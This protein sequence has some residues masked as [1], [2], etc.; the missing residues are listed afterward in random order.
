MSN[1]QSTVLKEAFTSPGRDIQQRTLQVWL[2]VGEHCIRVAPSR[3]G[4]QYSCAHCDWEACYST[5][6]VSNRFQRVLEE[7][8]TGD[9]VEHPCE[10][11]CDLSCGMNTTMT[12]DGLD[13]PI[14][15][16]NVSTTGTT[17]G[18]IPDG[19]VTYMNNKLQYSTSGKFY[20][21]TDDT[22]P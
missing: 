17:D 13:D 10:V 3:G 4:M 22:L 9:A 20:T 12:F 11:R 8:V 7:Y 14:P 18:S 21:I 19:T 1:T 16:S 6:D 15:I 2:R 5:R